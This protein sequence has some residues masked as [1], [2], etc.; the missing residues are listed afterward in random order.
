MLINKL[1]QQINKLWYPKVYKNGYKNILL[2]PFSLIYFT[3]IK[4]KY[5]YYKYFY[6]ILNKNSDKSNIKI[7]VIIIGNITVGGTGKTPLV[8]YL[9]KELVK[10]GYKPGIISRGYGGGFSKS[11]SKSLILDASS[12]P[13]QTGDE[14][15][16]IYNN[17]NLPVAIG[18]NRV[19]SIELLISKYPDINIIISDDGLQNYKLINYIKNNNKNNIEIIVIDS[20]RGFGNGAILPMGPLREPKSR[21]NKVDFVILNGSNNKISNNINLNKYKLNNKNNL[22]DL[23]IIPDNYLININNLNKL[24]SNKL[25][26]NKFKNTTVH[27]VAGIGNPDRFFKLLREN[28]INIIEHVYRD[29]YNYNILDLDFNDNLPIITTEK[30]AVKL[31]NLNLSSNNIW[32]LPITAEL[33]ANFI[34]KICE[35][36]QING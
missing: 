10:M 25:E 29:H 5:F 27:A 12:T 26:L 2:L 11:S 8:I 19:N 17:T 35:K 22:I 6:K 16:L 34:N 3:I 24:E 21:L 31:S 15:Y 9:A 32:Y 36:L 20:D 28:N 1:E 18:K 14:P 23:N 4:L 7:A 13:S 30:D 33:P